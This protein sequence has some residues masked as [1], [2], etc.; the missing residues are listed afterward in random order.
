MNEARHANAQVYGSD[1]LTEYVE[2]T[3][4]LSHPAVTELMLKQMRRALSLCPAAPVRVLDL[5]AGEGSVTRHW[6][7]LRVE[8]TAVEQSPAMMA[9]LRAKCAEH[10][11][12]LRCA[13][14]E[15]EAYLSECRE[16]FDIVSCIAFLHHVPDYAGLLELALQR[17]RKTGVIVTF[18][19]PLR[20]RSVP[21]GHR[22]FQ[23]FAYAAWRLWR[24]D[25]LGG[26]GR[27]IRRLRGVYLPGSA[28]DNAE[29]HVTRG[30]VDQDALVA[31]L[32]NKGLNV[33]IV[34]YWSSQSEFFQRTGSKLGLMSEFGLLAHA[35]DAG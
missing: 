23:Q 12:R 1:H 28:F 32:A 8:V 20:Y 6:L 16:Q 34:R 30:G 17:L 29:Y 3:P 4:H 14:M 13:T 33:E 2:T 9:E 5:G 24:P 25:V 19:D 10:G 7:A 21:R 15:V 11:D 26:I 27:R 22:L 35:G 31:L 18:A